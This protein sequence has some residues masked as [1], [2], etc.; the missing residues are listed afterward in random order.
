MRITSLVVSFFITLALAA[1]VFAYAA[2]RIGQNRVVVQEGWISS[3]DKPTVSDTAL[4]VAA[5]VETSTRP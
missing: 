3:S 5:T 2:D 1:L 4:S